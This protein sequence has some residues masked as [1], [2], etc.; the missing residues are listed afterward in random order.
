M[1][2]YLYILSVLSVGAIIGFFAGREMS[3]APPKVNVPPQT[4]QSDSEE[5][6]SILERQIE[7]Y[8]LKDALL[9]MRDCDKSFVEIDGNSGES[10]NLSQALV[11][12]HEMFQLEKDIRLQ[13]N[14][15]EVNITHNSA[16]IRS[17]YVRT[18]ES[19]VDQN[20]ESIVGEGLWLLTKNMK[21]WQITVF[22]RTESFQR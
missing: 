16:L 3:I 9:L 17:R 5:L 12:Y 8:R 18:S 14:Q 2:P 22:F 7:A 19:S 1:K 6:Q 13:L 10:Y 20:A 4:T 21:G 15:P 11:Y